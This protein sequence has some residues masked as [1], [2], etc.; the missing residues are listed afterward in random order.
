MLIPVIYFKYRMKSTCIR[1]ALIFFYAMNKPE[2]ILCSIIHC[3]VGWLKPGESGTVPS[4]IV[5]SSVLTPYIQ[6]V[7]PAA[8]TNL[9]ATTV[10]SHRINLNWTDASSN[11]LGFRLEMRKE[12]EAFA[13]FAMITANQT[14]Y[15]VTGL[16]PE[17]KYYFRIRSYNL[18]GNSGYSD[19]V[20]ATTFALPAGTVTR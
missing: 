1:N 19:S 13:E 16:T 9:T 18:T 7:L 17:T 10:S 20:H 2:I 8:P 11:E 12:G 5:P 6:A 3:S 15:Q 4:E 14:S